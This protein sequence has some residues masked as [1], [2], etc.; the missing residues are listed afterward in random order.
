MLPRE[1]GK[2]AAVLHVAAQLQ[3]AR[4]HILAAGDSGNDIDMLHAASHPIVVANRSQELAEWIADNRV[5]LSPAMNANGVVEGTEAFF[6][7]KSRPRLPSLERDT[8]G[9]SL[10]RLAA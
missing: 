10:A 7:C 2:G 4:S 3:I 6:A 8:V 1:A 9:L 5:H